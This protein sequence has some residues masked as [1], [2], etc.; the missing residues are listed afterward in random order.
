MAIAI[1]G[2]PNVGKSSLFNRLIGRRKSIVWD[3]P[4][5][6]RDRVKGRWQLPDQEEYELWDLAGWGDGEHL[7][8]LPKEWLPQIELFLFVVDGSMELTPEDY[9]CAEQ[10][11][12]FGIPFITVINKSD[13]KAYD[14]FH[15]Q[16]FNFSKKDPVL[17][18]AET[19]Q[20]TD[21][22]IESVQEILKNRGRVRKAPLHSVKSDFRVLIL[23]R[24]NAGKSS[25]I[26]RLAGT[27]VSIVSETPGTTRDIVEI[28]RKAFGK[29]W[30]FLDTAGVRK[31]ARI[32]DKNDPVE[33]FSAT[34]ALQAVEQCDFVIFLMEPHQKGMM[35]TQDKKL[36]KILKES[37]KPAILAVNKWDE[38]RENWKESSYRKQLAY[39]L[40]EFNFLPIVF[41]SAK[42]GYHIKALMEE[43]KKLSQKVKKY[44][45]SALNK[46]LQDLNETRSPRIV[47]PGIKSKGLRTATQYLKF[48]YMVQ[49][50]D[51]PMSFQIFCNAPH[52]VPKDEKKYL[53]N[54]LREAFELWG[55]PLQLIFR[56]KHSK[57]LRNVVKLGKR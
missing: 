51:S 19:K 24:P 27:E 11:R 53:E 13:K 34:K 50:S 41:V 54:K 26:N 7:K 55:V 18:S 10:L 8:R 45:T 21:S 40:G 52:L 37:C 29:T 25:L 14:E 22:L 35:H 46:F 39:D 31:K 30:E 49:I 20:G 1:A 28:Q 2:R 4:G 43:L 32:Y 16:A 36:L 3:R 5:V 17:L 47:R 15:F 48:N 57:S 56:K 42:T 38:A 12:K 9:S 23:G 33:I 6:T 44:P